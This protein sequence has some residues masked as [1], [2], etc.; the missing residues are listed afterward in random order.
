M[1]GVPVLD[2]CPP[3]TSVQEIFD[4]PARMPANLEFSKISESDYLFILDM[5]KREIEADRKPP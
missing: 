3:I 4:S 5:A 2:T 1:D